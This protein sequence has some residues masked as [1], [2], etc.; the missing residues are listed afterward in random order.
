MVIEMRILVVQ[1]SD[2][3]KRN[4]HQQHHLMELLGLRGH[5]IRVIDYDVEWKNNTEE[6]GL[7][8]SPRKVFKEYKKVYNTNNV[9][10][11]RPPLIRIPVINYFSILYYHKQEIKRQLKE[12]KPDIIVGFGILNANIA[13]KLKDRKYIEDRSAL[14]IANKQLSRTCLEHG[15]ESEELGIVHNSCDEGLYNMKTEE[16]KE[17]FGKASLF[18][19]LDLSF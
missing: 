10:V 9:T 12:F 5:K 4:P 16:I 17:Q 13:S 1:E 3:I 2:W 6:E 18:L 14:S 8:K 7:Y 11:I 19:C 15:V